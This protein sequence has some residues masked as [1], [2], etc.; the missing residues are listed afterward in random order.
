MG[1]EERNQSECESAP[2]I[3]AEP[4]RS[5]LPTRIISNGECMPVPQT[6]KQK[7]VEARLR[8]H[9]DEANHKLGIARRR[10]LRSS[11]CRTALA[12]VAVNGVIETSVNVGLTERLIPALD[13]VDVSPRDE[14][15]TAAKKLDEKLNYGWKKTTV[16]PAD[17]PFRPGRQEG[18]TERDGF[19][20]VTTYFLQ[21][22]TNSMQF[23]LKGDKGA[24]TAPEIGWRTL[25]ELDKDPSRAEFLA[26][27]ARDF[28]TPAVQAAELA[29]HTKEI[30]KAGDVY[31][32][33]LT[34]EGLKTLLTLRPGRAPDVSQARAW[35]KFW[36][37]GG[38]LSQYE[39]KVK[40]TVK[41]GANESKNDYTT[42]VEI[43]DVGVTK[44]VVPEEAKNKLSD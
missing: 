19:T 28:R 43:L 42:L 22:K 34:Q 18:K 38:V 26:V 6:K 39:I 44:V 24:A 12:L 32:G 35:V 36:T 33:E 41:L 37:N 5:P 17:A 14:V 4:L 21:N 13:A 2:R 3:V 40:G 20:H 9:S 31:S 11:G 25:G 15:A 1:S 16:V 29:S 30:T 7:Q 8:E 27:V 23:V 10:F